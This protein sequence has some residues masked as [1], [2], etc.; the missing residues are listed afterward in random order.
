MKKRILTAIQFCGEVDGDGDDEDYGPEYVHGEE[1]RMDGVSL[2]DREQ[3]E[4][5]TSWRYSYNTQRQSTERQVVKTM[6]SVRVNE[7][8]DIVIDSVK[9]GAQED[10]PEALDAN[11]E[12]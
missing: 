9:D 1:H 11:N 8:G 10:D 12:F 5:T 2:D 4:E 7:I 6:A 3:D